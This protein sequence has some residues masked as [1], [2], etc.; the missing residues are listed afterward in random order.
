[1]FDF[2]FTLQFPLFK[3]PFFSVSVHLDSIPSLILWIIHSL[4]CSFFPFQLSL[5]SLFKFN[6]SIFSFLLLSSFTIVFPDTER[7]TTSF[8][9]PFSG[10]TNRMNFTLPVFLQKSPSQL[11]YQDSSHF[12]VREENQSR[13][14]NGLGKRY[15]FEVDVTQLQFRR[16]CCFISVL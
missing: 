8:L 2:V 16:H 3:H 5:I 15:M 7:V 4:T 12:L 14:P 10:I 1:M 6:F 13:K 9:P 11:C